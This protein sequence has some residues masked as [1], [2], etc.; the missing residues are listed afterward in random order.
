MMNPVGDYCVNFPTSYPILTDVKPLSLLELYP[1]DW[2]KRI[3]IKFRNKDSTAPGI[4]SFS[5][6]KLQAPVVTGPFLLVMGTGERNLKLQKKCTSYNWD[7]LRKSFMSS[8]N[9]SH[10]L[11]S[12]YCPKWL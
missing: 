11:E 4:F 6:E 1:P 3:G 2:Y 8:L 12:L 9:T 7:N 5:I 10:N